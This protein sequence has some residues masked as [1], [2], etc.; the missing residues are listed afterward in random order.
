MVAKGGNGI[1]NE[2]RRRVGRGKGGRT[3]SL[4]NSPRAKEHSND[5]FPQ[6]PGEARTGE[7]KEDR[8]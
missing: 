3:Y 2:E 8:E 4:G 5:V 6:A 1:L 7:A